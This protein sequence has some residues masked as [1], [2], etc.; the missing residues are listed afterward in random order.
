MELSEA[1]LEAAFEVATSERVGAW[2]ATPAPIF[3][4]KCIR[5]ASLALNH[6]KPV[7]ANLSHVVAAGALMSYAP[8]YTSLSTPNSPSSLCSCSHKE[9]ACT[10]APH[11]TGVETATYRCFW[12][13]TV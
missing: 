5:L 12:Q 10:T 13:V 1:D 7:M 6:H 2:V 4:R 3:G 11:Y 8:D 9:I